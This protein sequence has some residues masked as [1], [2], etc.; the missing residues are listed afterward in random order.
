MRK[1]A[2]KSVAKRSLKKD[3][4]SDIESLDLHEPQEPTAVRYCTNDTTYESLGEILVDNPNGLLVERDEL[5]SL[6]KHLDDESQKNARGF[7]MSGYS[8]QD[9]YR[10]DR[11][12]RGHQTIEGIA[13][14]IIGS[15]QPLRI[16]DYVRKANSDAWGGDGLIQRFSLMVWPELRGDW[17]NVDEYPDSKARDQA[18]EVFRRVCRLN[19]EDIGAQLEQFDDT[20]FLRFDNRALEEFVD[21]RDPLERLIRGHTLSPA[22][23]GHLAKY[24]KLVPSLALINHLADNGRGPVSHTALRRAIAFSKY[25]ET[26]ARRVYGAADMIEISAGKAILAHIGRGELTNGFT[27]RDVQRHGW[28]ELTDQTC[29]HAGLN[30]LVDLDYL[31][32][33]RVDPHSKGGRVKTTYE[34]NPKIKTA[35]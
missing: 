4:D 25:L 34:I 29:I 6:L 28:G 16:S 3:P 23:E 22:L 20:P 31:S 12:M 27:S 7:Y 35:M 5:I 33:K 9:P 26:H 17:R 24:R 1:E 14:S 15:T 18:W 30:L 8:G 13:L 2:A 11:I 32:E 19:I 10:F 21:W